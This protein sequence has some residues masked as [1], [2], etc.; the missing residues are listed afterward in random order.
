MYR[1]N[2]S[3]QG[4][5]IRVRHKKTGLSQSSNG[6]LLILCKKLMRDLLYQDFKDAWRVQEEK[7]KKEIDKSI[8]RAIKFAKVSHA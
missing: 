5:V 4:D 1:I 7:H 8:T 6:D 2:I 3:Y